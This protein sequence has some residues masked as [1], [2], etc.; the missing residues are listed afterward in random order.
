ML[1][2]VGLGLFSV[3]R[4]VLDGAH[5]YYVPQVYRAAFHR[6]LD[7]AE[8]YSILQ[9]FYSE[10]IKRKCVL[11]CFKRFCVSDLSCGN[12]TS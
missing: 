9:V 6:A 2:C 11:R 7:I 12:C 3:R 1:V 8:N 10:K 5:A 4:L